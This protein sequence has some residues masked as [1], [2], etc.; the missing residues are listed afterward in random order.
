MPALRVPAAPYSHE[1]PGLATRICK[2]GSERSAL[3]SDPF[4]RPG[5]PDLRFSE[6]LQ[7]R[8]GRPHD[9]FHILVTGKRFPKPMTCENA[10]NACSG[11]PA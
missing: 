5:P 8:G 7:V 2:Q 4:T 6:F 3:L 1:H 10:K 11:Q 9:H